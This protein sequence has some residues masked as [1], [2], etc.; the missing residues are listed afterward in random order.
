[1]TKAKKPAVKKTAK[2]QQEKKIKA[3]S[4]LS[5]LEGMLRRP[6]GATIAQVVKALDWQAHTVRGAMSGTVK[7]KG[8]AVSSTK[9]EGKERV[10]RIAG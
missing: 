1:M 2:A 5:Q 7:K 4:K 6:E 10:Y 8:L 9:E 3:G